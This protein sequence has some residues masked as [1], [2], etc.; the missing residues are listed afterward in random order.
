[1]HRQMW[2]VGALIL[3][4]GLSIIGQAWAGTSPEW[5]PAGG[6]QAEGQPAIAILASDEQAIDLEVSI[7]GLYRE[8]VAT[9]GGEFPRLSIPPEGF[10]TEIGRAQLPVI[11]R[12]VE[13]PAGA[14]VELEVVAAETGLFSLGELAIH[15]LIAPVQRPVPKVPGAREAMEFELNEDFYARDHWYPRDHAELAGVEETRGHRLALIKVFPIR[16]N[17]RKEEVS[18]CWRLHLRL[19]LLGAD[20]EETNRR[21]ERWHSPVFEEILQGSVLNYGRYLTKAVPPLPIGYLIITHDD[22]H[23]Q[24]LPLAQWKKQKGFEVTVTQLSDI[25]PQSNNGIKDY[26]ADAYQNWTVPPTYVLLVGDVGYIPT[27]NG[28]SSTTETDLPYSDMEGSYFPELELGRFSVSSTTEAAAIVDKTLD[29]EQ[30]NLATLDWL[31][32]AV[33]MASLDNYVISEGTHNYVISTYLEPNGFKSYKIYARLGGG[34]SDITS[35]INDGRGIANYSGHGNQTSWSNPGFGISNINALTNADKYPFVVSN[36]CLTTDIGYGE[37]Y[38]EHWVNVANKGAIAHWG[39]S[40]YT[41]WD[42]DDILEKRMYQAIFDDELFTLAGFTNQAKWYH[43]QYYGGGGL[44]R[45]YYECY[46]LLG[47]PSVELPTAMPALLTVDHPATVPLGPCDV[48]VTVTQGGSPVEDALVCAMQEGGVHEA[49]YTSA[50]GQA[51]LSVFPGA[52]DTILV[53]VTA[54]NC[55][56]YQGTM[57][58]MADVPPAAVTDLQ[59]ELAATA[60]SLSWSPV[61]TDTLANPKTVTGYVI[62]RSVTPDFQP[63]PAS[64]LGTTVAPEYV[65]ATAAVSDTTLNHF[66]QVLAVDAEGRKSPSSDMVGE[67]DRW[68]T[69]VEP[70]EPPK[71]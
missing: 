33:F 47:D 5:I 35:N 58:P 29:Y 15:G 34:T 43:Y 13:I 25:S 31:G 7:P 50:S 49:G 28:S 21:L 59:V 27:F 3:N 61:T 56:P 1:L 45:Y 32:R 66:Y 65:D 55:R 39:S 69:D 38:G 2:T 71:R 37:C 18:I 4:L 52:S 63:D 68:V 53:T 11:T 64:S 36:A 22:F 20:L 44:S 24:I 12:L 16:Y 10:T 51:V 70:P 23:D 42:E 26:I 54:H 67:F 62:Y 14:R 17:P 40:N 30:T 57:V 60:L 46:I 6:P 9:P 8:M 48:T 19:H 41:Y